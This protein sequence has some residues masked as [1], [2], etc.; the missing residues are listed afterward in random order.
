MKKLNKREIESLKKYF[1]ECEYI[2][3][4][5]DAEG[6]G[7]IFNLGELCYKYVSGKFY[8]M[9]NMKPV[10]NPSMLLIHILGKKA[11]NDYCKQKAKE[12]FKRIA[13]VFFA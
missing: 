6:H 8:F 4:F 9:E 1:S 12:E 3:S 5:D 2:Q 7:F 13:K 10:C 11:A